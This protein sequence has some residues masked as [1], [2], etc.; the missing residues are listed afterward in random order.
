MTRI[1][2]VRTEDVRFP[3][4]RTL[5][6]SD[7]R[8][9]DPDYS[10]AYVTLETDDPN[11]AGFG[12][13]FT[14][15]RGTEICVAAIEALAPAVRGLTLDAVE[16]DI[17]SIVRTLTDDSQLRWLGPENGVIHLAAGAL[18]N[19]LWDLRARRA[20]LPLWKLLADLPTDAL[21]AAIDFTHLTDVLDPA[22]AS[23]ILDRGL[24]GL[25]ERERALRDHGIPAYT[26]SPGWLGLSDDELVRRCRAAVAAGFP[27]VKLK[28]GAD[29]ERDRHR[30][31]LARRAL[32]P[33]VALAVD[34]NQRW[35]VAE[36]IEAI[37]ALEPF[38]LAWV[39]EPCAPD[40]VLGHASIAAAVDV[41]IATGEH[42]ANR[43]LFKQLLA[44]GG[45]EVCQI[46]ACRV[47]GV[48][49][50]LAILL[51]AAVHDVPVCAHAGGVG[52]C[53]MVQ[54]L[55]AFDHL[56]VSRTWDR[57]MTEWTDHLHEHLRHPAVVVDGR[58]RC[59]TDP[60]YATELE[61]SSVERHRFPNGPEW[62]SP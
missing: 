59:P 47:A 50:N 34:A 28:V 11:L 39:E 22:A 30:L 10:L 40:D 55:A 49:D 16:R 17:G 37:R 4:S 12:S 19:G 46:D 2:A 26:T 57:R 41:P 29:P 54:H 33:D 6:G 21:V 58:Y 56:R 5:D 52:L 27:M 43:V 25:P 36:A 24:V 1:T 23:E 9:H 14:I 62:S 31:D 32:G 42:G 38:G 51:L 48:N 60:G 8:H 20:G 35:E 13:T 18:V 45:M 15:G 3:T 44:S 61:P 53:E 7:A